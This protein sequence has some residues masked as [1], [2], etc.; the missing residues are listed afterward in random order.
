M[1]PY[2]NNGFAKLNPNMGNQNQQTNG[3]G[4]PQYANPQ[5]SNMNQ[6]NQGYNP[7]GLQQQMMQEEMMRRQMLQQQMMQQQMMQQMQRGEFNNTGMNPGFGNMGM[8]P[9]PMSN[10]TMPLNGGGFGS[11]STQ[12]QPVTPT[13]RRTSIRSERRRRAETTQNTQV[14]E[15]PVEVSTK[16]KCENLVPE[17]GHEFPPYYDPDNE[18]IEKVI[19]EKTCTYAW[20][21]IRN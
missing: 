1:N 19:N 7:A 15:T 18:R 17:D 2:G 9:A 6:F 12:T 20:K 21:L 5:Y 8:N 4:G 16:P 3:F 11:F 10:S 14:R 13:G